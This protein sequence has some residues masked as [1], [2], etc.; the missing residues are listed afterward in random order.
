[1]TKHLTP[2]RVR[3][4]PPPIPLFAGDAKPHQIYVFKMGDLVKVGISYD[5]KRRLKGINLVMME[6]VELMRTRKVPKY[7][8]RWTE[9]N[10][11]LDLA[12]YHVKG[13]WFRCSAAVAIKAVYRCVRLAKLHDHERKRAHRHRA[14]IERWEL[15]WLQS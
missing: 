14:G 8:A 13:E 5:A 15:E 4:D 9:Q 11:H 10:A 7:L 6:P 3:S 2:E 12:P 1:M